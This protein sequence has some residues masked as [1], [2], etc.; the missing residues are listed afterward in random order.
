MDAEILFLEGFSSDYDIPTSTSWAP[1]QKVKMY[2]IPDQIF[3][4]YNRAQV[5]TSMGLFAELNHA[6]VTIDNAL[7]MW[8][9]THP[10]PQLVGFE[11][12]PNSIN[13]VKL[14]RPRK[15]VFLPSVTHLL[16]V[17]TTAEI[18]LLGLGCE[19]VGGA[20]TVSLYQ[21]GMFVHIKG[22][23]VHAI[24]SS[25]STGRIFFSSTTDNDVHELT[26]QQEERWFQGKCGKVN[27]TNQN[28]SLF[29]SSFALKQPTEHVEQMVVDDTRNLLYTLSSN[30][31]IRVFH[32][33]PNGSLDLTITKQAID[34]YSNLGHIISS[35][36]T[37]NRNIKIVAISPIPAAEASRYHLV[38][39]TAT[40]YRIYLSAHGSY[41]WSANSSAAN[42]PTSM[43][44]QHIIT[45]PS[46][47]PPAMFNQQLPMAG[48]QFPN[49]SAV[50]S[51]IHSLNPTSSAQRFP[52]GYFFCFTQ[53]DPTK[54]T[55]SLFIST[56][57]S[58]RL[59]KPQDTPIP[60]KPSEVGFWL[61]LGSRAEDIGLSTPSDISS[62]PTAGF[63]NELSIQFDQPAVEIAVLTNTGV[64]VIRRRRLVD[65]FAS[66]IR[67]SDDAEEGLESQVKVFIRLYGRSETLATALA[68]ACGQ[69]LDLSSDTRLSRINDPD[70]L[71]FARKV[72]IEF[73]GKPTLNEN[74][75]TDGSSV[76]IDAVA[77][78]P[79]HAG[80]AL[81]TSRLLRSI[82]KTVIVNQGRSPSGGL[83]V[84]P[85]VSVQSL[86][87]IQRDLSALQEFFRANRTFIEGLSGPEA[88]TRVATKQE[89]IALQ[90]EHRALHSLV[91]L[92]SHTIEG[93]SF[94]LVLF[95]NRVEEII[96]LLTEDAKTKFLELTFEQLFASSKGQDIAKELVKAIVNQNITRGSNVETVAE[97]LRRKCGSF[98]SSDDVLIFK[99]QELLKRATESGPNSEYGRNLLNESLILLKQVSENFPMD[100][101]QITVD[102]YIQNQFFAGMCSVLSPC[103]FFI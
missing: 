10:N 64:H 29:S 81:Y 77:P 96:T 35:N 57:D 89:E 80:I 60:L 36:E 3:D 97:A 31:S 25:D 84:S 32:L 2:K 86:Q 100:Y 68:V 54:R 24:G 90:A 26:Y 40:G 11:D 91:Q 92:I 17:S 65:I 6:W 94:I 75:V 87:A 20:T 43:Q 56:P 48:G 42:A 28:F 66:L 39:T 59:A 12:Q 9:Y 18:F 19:T 15:G 103:L 21:T 62:R 58:G 34:I 38:A 67:N 71:E 85:S 27:H 4:Q 82:W 101:L 16:V 99:G 72:F 73:G 76:A 70:V 74:A 7:Y 22:L 37:L 83:T 46:D 61:P 53:K 98:C 78:S 55:D 8:D 93:I 49:S 45:P 50:S 79:R 1:F 23:D 88:L 95:E 30:S 52:P 63:G 44:A 69:G 102:Q 47:T 14:A 5:S 13:A 33:K 41:S 51:P